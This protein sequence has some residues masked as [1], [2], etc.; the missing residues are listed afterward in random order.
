M[1]IL[2]PQAGAAR[3]SFLASALVH[4]SV[5]AAATWVTVQTW[6]PA[7]P[8]PAA[9]VAPSDEPADVSPVDEPPADAGWPALPPPTEASVPLPK[10]PPP[11]DDSLERAPADVPAVAPPRLVPPPRDWDAIV[12][13]DRRRVR[14]QALAP[15][16]TPADAS[17]VEA[18]SAPVDAVL[19][20]PV[21]RHQPPP[22]R[23]TAARHRTGTVLLR[24]LVAADGAVAK[25]RVH[26]SSGV[27]LLDGAAARAAHGWRFHPATRAGAPLAAWVEIPVRF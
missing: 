1:K 13:S 14:R 10:D 27:P 7:T 5:A 25:V 26:E 24:V 4:T 17:P 21:P 23:P 2:P 9:R 15:V 19:V 6:A 20:P 12:G 11:P 3:L 18:T 8:A 22:E 16:P